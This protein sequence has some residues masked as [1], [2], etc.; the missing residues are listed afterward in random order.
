MINLIY[1]PGSFFFYIAYP[2]TGTSILFNHKC[3]CCYLRLL[4]VS[5]SFYVFPRG[6]HFF[7]ELHTLL[8]VLVFHT[9]F[10]SN[11]RRCLCRSFEKLRRSR[12]LGGTDVPLWIN[13]KGCFL[14]V[15]TYTIHMELISR[16]GLRKRSSSVRGSLE[17]ISSRRHRHLQVPH[18][19]NTCLAMCGGVTSTK[20]VRLHL[21]P[22]GCAGTRLSGARPCRS[23]DGDRILIVTITDLW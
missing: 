12:C 15:H 17:L 2:F 3:S 20:E 7:A 19:E 13:T 6:I 8:N 18:C 23:K 16:Q 21:T 1:S 11:R 10:K 22:R 14:F 9:S 4:P 5:E